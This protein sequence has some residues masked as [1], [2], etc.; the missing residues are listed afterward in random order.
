MARRRAQE[1]AAHSQPMYGWALQPNGR[2]VPIGVAQRGAHG[3]ICP[4][5]QNSVIARKGDIKQHHFS[6]EELTTCTPEAVA[7]AIGGRWLMLELGAAMVL[8]R[9][10]TVSWTIDDKTSSANLMEGVVAL[11][12]ELETDHGLADIALVKEDKSIRAVI[13][14]KDHVSD[15]MLN[16]F[17]AG[18]VTVIVPP[19][20][21][22][23]SG[24]INLA[25]LLHNSAIYGGWQLLDEFDGTLIT[26]GSRIREILAHTVDFPPY[27]FWAPLEYF[28]PGRP[29]LR[30]AEHLVW[31]PYEVWRAVIGG[32]IHRLSDLEIT[33]Q[34]WEPAGDGSV[35]VLFYVSLRETTAVA[36][37]R[38]PS[39]D[40]VHA[41]MN[42]A[43]RL[44]RTTAAEVAQ[45]LATSA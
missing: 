40:Q 45:L 30:V 36:I 23:R 43:Y 24:Q 21:A 7:M 26:D 29:V 28:G 42:S 20:D 31:L 35:T 33:I 6:H 11:A 37:R 15:M 41:T 18:G 3:Y 2:P 25:T 17:V 34:Q 9:S 10:V 38:F 22:F 19:L 39:K 14:L 16:Q 44:K 1:S 8:R 32:T 12:D 13:H 4:I 27:Y 5:C